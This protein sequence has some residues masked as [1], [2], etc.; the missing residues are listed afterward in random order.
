M[1]STIG[2]VLLQILAVVLPWFG[3][4]VGTEALTTTIQTFVLIAGG[5]WIWFE[6][7]K[8]GDVNL[9]GVRK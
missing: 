5:L 2:A 8:R 6:R 4:T 3:I 9:F 1:S 7:V